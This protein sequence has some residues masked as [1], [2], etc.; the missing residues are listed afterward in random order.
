[1]GN[2]K[3]KSITELWKSKEMEMIRNTQKNGKFYE[4]PR[5]RNCQMATDADEGIPTQFETY[6]PTI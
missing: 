4:I 1:M 3:T 6:G 2:V 5:C